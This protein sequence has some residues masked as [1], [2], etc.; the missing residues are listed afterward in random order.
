MIHLELGACHDVDPAVFHPDPDDEN[1]A[2]FAKSVCACCVIRLD[3]LVLALHTP[4]LD[5]VWGGLT[6]VERARHTNAN[7]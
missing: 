5:G 3:C 1:A 4:D 7:Q 2:E 6:A